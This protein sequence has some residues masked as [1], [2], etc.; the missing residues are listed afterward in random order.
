MS[1]EQVFQRRL[2]VLRSGMGGC[3]RIRAADV[4]RFAQAIRER[5][6]ISACRAAADL[7]IVAAAFRRRGVRPLLVQAKLPAADPIDARRIADSVDAGMAVCPVA[8]TC[9]RRSV[10]LLRELG[11]QGL[12]ATLHIGVR[13]GPGGMQAHAWVQVG[14]EVINDDPD[15]VRNFSRLLAGDAERAATRLL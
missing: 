5:H 2:H 6:R 8:A 13:R 3:R 11:R 1:S 12:G 9:L 7:V 15:V 4:R 14:D 10:V